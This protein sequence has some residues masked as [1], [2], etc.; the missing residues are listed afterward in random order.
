[1]LI[2]Y[3]WHLILFKELY[4]SLGI[5]NRPE[6]IIPL[7]FFSMIIQGVI[8]A[9]LYPFFAKDKAS[10]GT[11][12]KF[13]LILGFF[14]FSVSTLANGAKILVNSMQTWLCIQIA[15][16]L[17]QFVSAGILIGLVNRK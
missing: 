13:C 6:P 9:Y 2:G 17:L 5:Y 15:F 11:A 8:L 7:G 12:I 10:I 4:D 1:M 16:T 14:I 3:A